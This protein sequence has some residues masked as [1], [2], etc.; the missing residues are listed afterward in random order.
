MDLH[1]T[2]SVIQSVSDESRISSIKKEITAV[3]ALLRND[4]QVFCAS[5]EFRK[6][7]SIKKGLRK[8]YL[9]HREH[10]VAIPILLHRSWRFFAH[11]QND[12]LS[13]CVNRSKALL[14]NVIN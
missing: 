4:V 11:A 8:I 12:G 13:F 5:R 10:S 1:K 2:R 9:R 6:D 7:S 14:Q 3:A